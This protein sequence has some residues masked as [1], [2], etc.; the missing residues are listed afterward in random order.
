MEDAA[1]QT[2]LQGLHLPSA[3]GTGEPGKAR[4]SF[5]QEVERL[6]DGSSIRGPRPEKVPLPRFVK[7]ELH[8]QRRCEPCLYYRKQGCWY[9][10]ECRFCHL[11]TAE[12]IRKWQSRQHYNQRAQ[13]REK[14]EEG[15]A[16]EGA[17]FHL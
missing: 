2:R 13:Q 12:Q 15:Q 11:C 10:D 5:S 17:R 9:G 4:G 6:E 7:R 8:N 1:F 3:A 16:G 14:L